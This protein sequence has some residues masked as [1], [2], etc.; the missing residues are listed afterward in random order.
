MLRSGM[1][2]MAA[3]VF[4]S[5]ATAAVPIAGLVNSGQI[6]GGGGVS[7]GSVR[8]A[9]WLMDGVQPW[10]SSTNNG[11]WLA[12]NA[13]SRWMTPA[14]NGNQSFDPTADRLYLYTLSFDL[15]GFNPATASFNGR[16]AV[17]NQV[18]QILLNGTQ[19][20]QAGLGLFNNWTA[21]SASS[22]FVSG[23]NTLAFTVRNLRQASGNPTGLRVEFL[24]SSVDVA[25]SGSAVPEPASWAMMIAGFGLVG[26]MRRRRTGSVAA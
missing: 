18:T 9:N 11:A 20:T 19:I 6:V 15:T 17:D 4:A 21:F 10:N 24:A 8:E 23:V 14:S 12:N 7:S 3:A 5:A 22:G 13:V 16:F 1:M 2:M 26:A 25:V